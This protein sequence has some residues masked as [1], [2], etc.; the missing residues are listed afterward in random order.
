MRK[1]YF[2]Y[3]LTRKRNSTFYI[4][5]T[6][7][8]FR[9]TDEHKTGIANSFTKKYNI[10]MLVYYEMHDDILTA[11]YRE[12]LI[13]KWRRKIKIKAIEKMNPNWEDL[14]LKLP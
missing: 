3:I 12:K 9:R 13:K 14:F 10:K 6:N 8:L 1:E 2:V 7:N 4:G 11:I 5:V